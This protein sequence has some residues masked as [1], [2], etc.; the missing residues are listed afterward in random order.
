MRWR[1]G[2]RR[3]SSGDLL[4]VVSGLPA[5]GK[6]T[7]A[8]AVSD[9]LCLPVVERDRLAEVCF[10]A[11]GADRSLPLGS[12]SYE[13]LFH[14]A[15][16]YLRSGGSLIV[17]SNFSRARHE[18]QLRSLVA[19]TGYR[20]VELHCHAPGDVLLDRYA[21]RAV[22]GG[23]HARHDDVHRVPEFRAVF[24]DPARHRDAILFPD[25][26]LL[27]DTTTGPSTDAVV[28]HLMT[29]D[30]AEEPDPT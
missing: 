25:R 29:V 28:Q 16:E 3:A 30:P 14:V 9:R 11:L 15:G 7:L 18:R 10:E 2:D 19:G 23:R 27:L 12:V 13:L 4:V 21:A 26:A 8:R 1:A 6:T 17:E 22:G 24:A 20:I 5:S